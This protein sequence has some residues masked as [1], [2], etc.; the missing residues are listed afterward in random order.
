MKPA[1]A[2]QP[3]LPFLLTSPCLSPA[4]TGGVIFF[5]GLHLTRGRPSVHRIANYFF[6]RFGFRC[7]AFKAAILW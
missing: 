7:A 2:F 4:Q 3:D 5:Q 1:I 6:A